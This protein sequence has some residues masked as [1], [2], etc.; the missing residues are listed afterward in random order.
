[1]DDEGS[2]DEDVYF[3][4]DEDTG[5]IR[6]NQPL[7]RE[8]AP[9]RNITVTASEVG[10]YP[11]AALHEPSIFTNARASLFML[12]SFADQRCTATVSIRLDGDSDAHNAH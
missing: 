5:M 9:W 12:F 4:V 3:T 2:A 10:R 7:D 11:P 1:M 6:T 8:A